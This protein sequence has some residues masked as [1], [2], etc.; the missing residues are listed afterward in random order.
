M[1]KG[2]TSV[3]GAKE[4]IGRCKFAVAEAAEVGGWALS[5]LSG[6]AWQQF[7]CQFC[8]QQGRQS[9]LQ[10][11]R[12]ACNHATLCIVCI[13]CARCAHAAPAVQSPSLPVDKW[14]PL[15]HGEYANEDG[16]VSRHSCQLD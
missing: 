15:G 16:C 3:L 10:L 9:A 8:W 5:A 7:Y 12:H 6:V 11:A 2:A 14:M 4:F 1:F 13:C